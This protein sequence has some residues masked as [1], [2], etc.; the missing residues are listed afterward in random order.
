MS[1][2]VALRGLGHAPTFQE[3]LALRGLGADEPST[4]SLVAA[5]LGWL[6]VGMVCGAALW[7]TGHEAMRVMRG[8]A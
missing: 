8:K 1:K 7:V 4:G 2:I 6:A 5:T 3:Q